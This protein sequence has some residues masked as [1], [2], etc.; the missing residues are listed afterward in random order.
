MPAS[1]SSNPHFSPGIQAEPADANIMAEEILL[2]KRG[3]IAIITFNREK[4]LNALNSDLYFKLA[5]MMQQVAAMPEIFITVIT[6]KGR[7]FSR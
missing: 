4:K 5:S 7:F 1:A 3:K 2:E 6:G